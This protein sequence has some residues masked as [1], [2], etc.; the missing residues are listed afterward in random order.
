MVMMPFFL[1][2]I[3]MEDVRAGAVTGCCSLSVK[4]LAVFLPYSPSRR[5]LR[6]VACLRLAPLRVRY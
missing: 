6:S 4:S 1:D 5:I 2:T 3:H